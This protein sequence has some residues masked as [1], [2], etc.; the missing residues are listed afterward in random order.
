MEKKMDEK[1]L[2]YI[3]QIRFCHSSDKKRPPRRL[4]VKG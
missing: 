3:Q 4:G 1:R 2:S